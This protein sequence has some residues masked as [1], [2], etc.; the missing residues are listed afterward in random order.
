[1]TNLDTSKKKSGDD[2]GTGALKDE[3]MKKSNISNH[4][5]FKYVCVPMLLVQ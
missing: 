3:R 5:S 4:V 2:K 1:M